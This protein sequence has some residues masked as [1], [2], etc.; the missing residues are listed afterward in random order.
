L[1]SL[2]GHEGYRLDAEAA[3]EALGSSADAAGMVFSQN[4]SDQIH[5]APGASRNGRAAS[6]SV[7]LVQGVIVPTCLEGIEAPDVAPDATLGCL[8]GSNKVMVNE[9]SD[10]EPERI[11]T[12]DY[13]V[14]PVIGEP[15][16]ATRQ[17]R[18]AQDP[19]SNRKTDKRDTAVEG[20]VHRKG[21]EWYVFRTGITARVDSR[22]RVEKLGS[23]SC[24]QRSS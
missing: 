11:L 1:A 16:L 12:S 4:S 15:A 20:V 8:E 24:T 10:D 2:G 3:G 14:S 7:H 21:V 17:S 19:S 13:P 9:D 23:V 6:G 5:G 18:A 22:G